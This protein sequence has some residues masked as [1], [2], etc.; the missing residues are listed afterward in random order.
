MVGTRSFIRCFT[1][2]LLLVLAVAPIAE[3]EVTSLPGWSGRLKSKQYSGYLPVGKASG[4]AGMIHYWF[5]ESENDPAN[6]PVVYWTNGG[7][8]S[9]GISLGLLTELG[10]HR[11]DDDSYNGTSELKVKYNPYAWSQVA[12]T[13]FVSQPKGVGFSYCVDTSQECRN[14]D[15][16]SAQDAYEFFVAFFNGYPEFAKNDFYLTG[17]SY[18]GI[19]IPLFMQEIEK[20]GGLPNFKG[21]AIGDGCWGTDVGLCAFSSGKSNQIQV[22]FFFG[23]NMV[24]QLTYRRI[25]DACGAFSDDDVKKE[26][27]KAGLNQMS[28]EIG[29]FDTYNVY[30]TCA[31]DQQP[32]VTLADYN[33]WLSNKTVVLLDGDYSHLPHPQIGGALN[34]YTCGSERA[35]SAWLKQQNVANALHVKLGTKGMH[36]TWGPSEVSGDLRPLYKSLASKYRMLIYSGDTDGCVPEW[37]TEEWVRELGFGVKSP[38]RPWKAPLTKGAQPQRAG[39]VTEYDTNGFKLVT[40]QGAG[41]M[42]PTYKPNFALTMI[43]NFLKN[44]F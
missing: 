41:H 16:T 39:Y 35:S 30:D 19:Y 1:G 42:V 15:R 28:S 20:N 34:D 11:L 17:E 27:C 22:E 24:S 2:M 12:N 9:S 5:I 13:L 25:I 7:P 32:P 44:E 6:D 40:I 29:D 10:Q 18:G 8:G 21:G 38:W 36:Y 33:R 23:H 14:N 26:A 43:T 37:G 3:H 31:D 4:S